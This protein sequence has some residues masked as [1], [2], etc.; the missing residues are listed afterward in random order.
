[1]KP[2]LWELLDR[3]TIEKQETKEANKDGTSRTLSPAFNFAHINTQKQ[4]CFRRADWISLHSRSTFVSLYHLEPWQVVRWVYPCCVIICVN[5]SHKLCKRF[6][7]CAQNLIDACGGVCSKVF[8]CFFLF[9]MRWE[10][11]TSGDPWWKYLM[12][13]FISVTQ[14]QCQAL[15]LWNFLVF[16]T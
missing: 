13:K 8:F 10:I 11:I 16:L 4:I 12:M 3:L 6:P 14:R 9:Q 15:S 7:N 5:T 2:G 1:M